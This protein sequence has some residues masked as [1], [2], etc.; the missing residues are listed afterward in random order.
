MPIKCSTQEKEMKILEIDKDALVKALEKLPDLSDFYAKKMFDGV[1]KVK[2]LDY[3]DGRIRESHELLRIR[4]FGDE[5]TEVTYKKNKRIEDGVKVYDEC[6]YKTDSF[7]KAEEMFS[8]LGLKET[9]KYEKKRTIYDIF[10]N[11]EKVAQV[12][13][14]EYP[15]IPVF[16][17][18]EASDHEMIYILISKLKLDDYEQSCETI[19]ELIDRKYPNVNLNN[20][21]FN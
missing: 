7:E 16:C 11:D 6:E 19:N 9:C 13:I 8:L 5:Y 10:K 18:V 4:Q 2:Y 20:L 1:L 14:D 3:E 12:V 15:Q 17:E 21:C